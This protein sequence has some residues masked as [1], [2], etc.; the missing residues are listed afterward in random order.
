MNQPTV[1]RG[2]ATSPDN[3]QTVPMDVDQLEKSS[4]FAASSIQGVVAVDDSDSDVG[5]A[6]QDSCPGRVQPSGV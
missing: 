2:P 4:L 6:D 5:V 1:H 3:F